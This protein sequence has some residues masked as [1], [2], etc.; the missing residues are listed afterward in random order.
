[1]DRL[2]ELAQKLLSL[3]GDLDFSRDERALN[4][5]E[6]A[7]QVGGRNSREFGRFEAMA[8]ERNEVF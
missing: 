1:M 8:E 6:I 2:N 5:P 4:S 3:V 7:I